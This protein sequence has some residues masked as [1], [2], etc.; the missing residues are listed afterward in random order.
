MMPKRC[1]YAQLNKQSSWQLA[2]RYLQDQLD[3][4][5]DINERDRYGYTALDN[6]IRYANFVIFQML[7]SFCPGFS[8]R[9]VIGRGNEQNEITPLQLA[10]M[11]G[12][13]KFAEKLIARGADVNEQNRG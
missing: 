5:R 9:R 8:T 1:L 3:G 2:A 11:K 6:S 7:L 4:G 13:P 10:C 12:L